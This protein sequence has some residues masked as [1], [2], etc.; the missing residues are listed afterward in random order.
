MAVNARKC[1]AES[2]YEYQMLYFIPQDPREA[3]KMYPNPM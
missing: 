1:L 3:I 2:G